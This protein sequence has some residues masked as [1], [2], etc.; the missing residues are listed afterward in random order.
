MGFLRKRPKENVLFLQFPDGTTVDSE[1][2]LDKMFSEFTFTPSIMSKWTLPKPDIEACGEVSGKLFGLG[3]NDEPF[4]AFGPV[5]L[6]HFTEMYNKYIA[7]AVLTPNYLI[8]YFQRSLI[9]PDYLI[10]PLLNFSGLTSTGPFSANFNCR[11]GIH[12][13]KKGTFEMAETFFGLSER[14]GKDGQANRRSITFIRS[15]EKTL[16]EIHSK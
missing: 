11:N 8:V 5:Y 14:L 3:F 7:D 15:L 9:R 4:F 2:D 1:S 16:N 13:N 6:S 12:R 10:L